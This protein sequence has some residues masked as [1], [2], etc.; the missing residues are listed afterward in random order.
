MIMNNSDYS[1]PVCEF[2]YAYMNFVI[3]QSVGV[4]NEEVGDLKDYEW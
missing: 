4:G 3:C 1:S 2:V